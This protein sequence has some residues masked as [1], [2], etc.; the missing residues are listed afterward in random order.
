M[1][2][3]SLLIRAGITLAVLVLFL[4]HAGGMPEVRL[5][6]QMENLA[7]DA[8]ARMT[9][10]GGGESSVVIVDIDERSIAVEGQWPWARDRLA[11]L[12]DRLFGQYDVRA[13]GFDIAFPEADANQGADLLRELAANELAGNADFQDAYRRLEPSL[14]TDERFAQALQGRASVLGFVLRSFEVEQGHNELGALPEPLFRRDELE[15]GLQVHRAYGYTGNIPVLQEKAHAAGFF[16]N[17]M[18]DQ[19]GVFRR[20]PLLQQYD[21]GIYAS[22]ALQLVRA[23]RDWA[24]LEFVYAKDAEVRDNLHLEW[25]RVDDLR[26]PVDG[27][28]AL[29][30]PYRGP[31]FTLPYISAIDVIRGTADSAALRDKVVLVGTSAPGLHDLRVTP[32]GEQFVGVEVHANIVDGILEQRVKYHPLYIDGAHIV[33]LVLLAVLVTFFMTR[34]SVVPATLA[35]VALAVVVV[36]ANLVLWEAYDVIVPLAP[37][38]LFVIA[39]FVMHILY[40][41]LVESRSKRH[42]SKMFGQYVPPEL[43]DEMDRSNA[44]ISLEGES[45]DMSVLFS[46]VRGFTSLSEGLEPKELTQLMNEFLTPLTRSIHERRGTIDKYMGDAIM[47]FWGAPL[48]DE[49]HAS[50]AV[51]AALDMIAIMHHLAPHFREKGWPELRV[52]VGVN[53]G[54]MNVGNMGSSF[55]M[56]YTVLGDA[57]N[58]GSRLE[59]LTKAYGVDVIV[60]ESTRDAAPEFAYL[61]LD[62][63]RVKGRENA[64]AIFEPLGRRDELP[65]ESRQLR[66][67]HKQALLLYREQ[68]WDAAER[69]FFSLLQAN[70]AR[71]LYSIYLERIARF[72]RQAPAPDWD[73]VF[74]FETK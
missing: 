18:V 63:V 10:P 15:P 45:R 53:T 66:A 19:D 8:R 42:L 50:H 22:L 54:V 28:L 44:K 25:L 35:T 17:P 1:Q 36:V 3:R 31:A 52:G 43:V 2:I 48:P 34:W 4:L 14:R 12:A 23:A 62:R 71:K 30:V 26:I 56:A 46:D 21:G 32:V 6:T 65:K 58:L 20:V 61:E 67:R 73:G 55:R 16:D 38:I 68:Q 41:L 49:E 74:V 33:L 40:G 29:Y 24:P 64:V 72:R 9:M 51:A 27:D 70:P 57:V 37:S 5:L 13:V 7:Y 39:A 59:G 69:E 47:A 11:V 60:S